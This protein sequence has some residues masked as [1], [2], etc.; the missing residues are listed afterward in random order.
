MVAL[1]M[2]MQTA[3]R[4]HT[5]ESVAKETTSQREDN[6]TG[7]QCA[8]RGDLICHCRTKPMAPPGTAPSSDDPKV[9]QQVAGRELH[10]GKGSI[11]AQRR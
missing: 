3:F 11:P 4:G 8:N 10:G 2:L 9:P 6:C 5:G 1:P 7:L